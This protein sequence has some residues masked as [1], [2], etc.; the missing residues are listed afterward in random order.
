MKATLIGATGLIG[1]YLMEELLND[2]YFDT[3]RILIR[4]PFDISHA[5]LEKKMVDF[6]DSDSLLI[7]MNYSDVVFCTV[8]TTQKKVKG[9]KDAYRKVDFDIPVNAAR[10][11]KMTGCERF[12]LVSSVGA[13]SRSKNFYLK[14]KGEVED[15]V[16][17]A[18]LKSVHIMR[19]SMLLGYRKEFRLGEMIGKGV[20]KIFS[21]LVPS[22]YKPVHGAD[23]A[24]AMKSVAKKN[25]EGFFVYEFNNIK[26]LAG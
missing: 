13:N 9:D 25:D 16:K 7:A 1:G 22:K 5:K 21:F 3:V 20:M 23:V 24:K 14:L 6:N 26:Q 12:V 19:P 15:A 17:V 10:F 2:D 8:G 11:C 18:G 4:R